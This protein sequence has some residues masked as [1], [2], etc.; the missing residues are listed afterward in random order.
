M[1]Q[2]SRISQPRSDFLGA[3]YTGEV[4][5]S[6]LFKFQVDELL[7]Q[8]RPKSNKQDAVVE[9]ELHLLKS[10]IDA[11]PARAPLST[12][13]AEA[14]MERNDGIVVPFPYPR[15][16]KDANYRLQYAKPAHV[17]AVGSYPLKTITKNEDSLVVDFVVTMPS[18][19][20]QEKDYMN[21]R[22]FYKR[23][24]YLACL[25]A[26]IKSSIGNKYS[27]HFDYLH[28]NRLLPV[29]VAE[30]KMNLAHSR[31]SFSIVILPAIAERLFPMEKLL[32]NKNC[33]R[34]N[35]MAGDS[36][37]SE[38]EPTPFYNASLRANA[39]VTAYLKLQ[40]DAS[41]QCDAYK[42]TCV[43]GRIWLRQRGLTSRVE[44]GGFGNFEWAVTVALL[45]QS[46]GPNGKPAFS[47]GYS[48]YQLFKATLKYLASK[49]LSKIPQTLGGDPI[50]F[51]RGQGVPVLFDGI[52][53]LNLF[54][55]MTA[56]SY[57]LLQHEARSSVA[58]LNDSTFDQFSA[59]FI[60]RVDQPVCK[61]DVN[62]K[63]PIDSLSNIAQDEDSTAWLDER[64]HDVFSC[65][66]QGLTD[67]VKLVSVHRP[68]EPQ[69]NLNSSPTAMEQA[70]YISVGL[71]VDPT[72]VHRLVD[73][74][75]A[76]EEKKAAVAFRKFWGTRAELRRFK[77]GSI[78][79][80]LV[81]SKK[82]HG[83]T[84]LQ[85]IIFY[86]LNRHLGEPCAKHS[87]YIGD[88]DTRLLSPSLKG[89]SLNES[90]FQPMMAA[91]KA[92]EDD[93]RALDDLPLHLRHVLGADSQLSH[94]SVEVPFA[95]GRTRM[96]TP[97]DVIIQF[98]GSARWP[99]DID[100]IQRTKTAFLLKLAELMEDKIPQLIA[101]VGLENEN[102]P[103]L[104]QA[105]LDLNYP[106][107][108]A[109]RLRIHHD[110]EATLLEKR[111]SAK[112]MVTLEKAETALALATYRR[113]FIRQPAHTQAL[114]NLVTRFP[115]LPTAIRLMKKWVSS[116]LLSPHLSE[117]LIELFVTRTFTNPYPWQTPSSATTG[118]LRTLIFLSRWDWRNEP[119]IVDLGTGDMK[120]NDVAAITTR[121]EAWRK[122]DPALNRVVMFA[123]SSIDV[124]GT[125]RTDHAHPPKVV[126]GRLTALA[127]S[128]V[129]VSKEKGLE[130]DFE[131]LFV[132]DLNDYDIIIR[133][134]PKFTKSTGASKP[135]HGG[136]KNLQLQLIR[137]SHEEDN[138][139]YS[140]VNLFFRELEQKFGHA[141]VFFWNS[142]GGDVITCLWNPQTEK[143]PWKLK[144]GYST[145]P[146]GEP[147]SDAVSVTANKG[148]ILNDIA[149]LGGDMVL[150]IKVK[151]S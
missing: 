104:N 74:G 61:Y 141:L 148:A 34:P 53:G 37:P 98:E 32:P 119:W 76:A 69:W 91:F 113:V 70:A 112:G 106:T 10:T 44:G 5:K 31:R 145:M 43:L 110:R 17:N 60:L 92:L 88:Q 84:I 6:N 42:D 97:A 27:L 3:A 62:I 55:K 138:V 83:S 79:E 108:A 124:D 80:S 121:F 75:P 57:R 16:P 118:F 40:H 85:Q 96:S 15:P 125:T 132:A 68:A 102:S 54:F 14:A 78:L 18:D 8:L 135:K 81:W 66:S 139:G 77:D 137:N 86:I 33:V 63:I 126:A 56:W 30:V 151:T 35:H 93:I 24:Y 26:G 38:K 82:D 23:A 107:G 100:A 129:R 115:A 109:F 117:P 144:V 64:C 51:P 9:K 101:R 52:R 143:R 114:Q 133:L 11:I 46:G 13:D 87:T 1:S 140:P 116:H 49:D 47:S 59:A 128:A 111:L 50:T 123:A 103:L 127:K 67:R 99:D 95:P 36:I 72:N 28:G 39:F 146:V 136:F 2:L 120:A 147:E 19:I 58:L 90:S 142:Y 25:A 29:L 71:L 134:N 45:L 48:S 122:I 150:D 89:S 4:F 12:R 65:L 94:G 149:R 21:Y 20:F 7:G 131:S 22:Y 105:F 73:H 130:L 41:R